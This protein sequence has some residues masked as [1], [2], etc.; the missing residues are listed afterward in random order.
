MDALSHRAIGACLCEEMTAS[1]II[2]A[3][4]LVIFGRSERDQRLCG[5]ISEP[6]LFV[7][8]DPRHLLGPRRGE[9]R[10]AVDI[11][12]AILAPPRMSRYPP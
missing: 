10:E 4:V 1:N 3:A 9:E 5:G 8:F 7:L 11:A 2:T 12:D 6:T